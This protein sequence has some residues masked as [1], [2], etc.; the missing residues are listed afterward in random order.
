MIKRREF[1]A[2]LGG[3]AAWPVVARAQQPD[4]GG[5]IGLL[6]S[7]GDASDTATRATI[8]AFREGL[9]KLG[10]IEE[11]NLRIDVRLGGDDDLARAYATELVSLN[12]DAIVT[13]GSTATTAVQRQTR[14]IPI[15]FVSVGDPVVVGIVKSIPRP[16]GNTTGITNSFASFGGKW[17]QLLKE[18]APRM[19]RIALLYNGQL[20]GTPSQLPSIEEA[21]RALAVQAIKIPYRNAADLVRGI[22]AFATEPNGGLIAVPP[23]PSAANRKMILELATQHQLPAIWIDRFSV[24][25]GGL[26]SY[27]SDSV[28]LIRR[29]SSFVDRILRGAKVS[30][31]PVEYPTKF[32]L[33]INLRAAKALGLTIPESLL[34]RAD[35]VIE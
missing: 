5:R 6:I 25:D 34:Q 18:A 14:T 24:V 11:R 33:V 31:L 16:E 26:M 28:D 15:V 30:E 10:W 3:A 22:D 8:A 19:E 12:P 17:L 20:T 4:R 2:G 7:G 9:A 1:I 29:A 35:E 13:R 27:G 21:A 23:P 32:E